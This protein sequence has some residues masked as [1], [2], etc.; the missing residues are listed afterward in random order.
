M[1]R[2][3]AAD[4]LH[5]KH[6]CCAMLVDPAWAMEKLSGIVGP[7]DFLSPM[8]RWVYDTTRDRIEAGEELGLAVFLDLARQ[9]HPSWVESLLDVAT[10]FVSANLGYHARKVR[11]ISVKRRLH[12]HIVKGEPDPVVLGKLLAELE[13]VE[14]EGQR[15]TQSLGSV[16]KEVISN[17]ARGGLDPGWDFLRNAVRRIWPEHFLVLGGYTSSGK[18]AF[19]VETILRICE[20]QPGTKILLVSTE[21]SSRT[22]AARMLG[23]I[24]GLPPLSI[25]LGEVGPAVQDALNEALYRLNRYQIFIRD[26]LYSVQEIE[27]EARRLG[28]A[29]VVVDFLQNLLV[30]DS[31]TLYER[32]SKVAIDLQRAAK[33]LGTCVIA[34]SQTSNEAARETRD[35]VIGTKGS[36]EIAAAADLVLWLERIPETPF[37]KCT[38]RKNRHGPTGFRYLEFVRRWTALDEKEAS[39]RP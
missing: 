3:S 33:K 30:P 35:W 9:S 24:S 2:S 27:R 36:G 20:R 19:L 10:D 26:D 22:Y 13:D 8:C 18:S 14:A 31:K 1:G 34:A 39:F 5:E 38:V 32:M 4:N 17:P 21:M 25:M 15:S 16:A 29:I 11:Q 6:L 7:E 28:P 12:A 23:G 37:V